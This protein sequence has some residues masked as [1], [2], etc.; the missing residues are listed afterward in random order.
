ML[1]DGLKVWIRC[2]RHG[3]LSVQQV[4]ELHER[5]GSRKLLTLKEVVLHHPGAG[6]AR[7]IGDRHASS[8]AIGHDQ[9]HEREVDH[10]GTL[11]H[12]DQRPERPVVVGQR[13][14]G[15]VEVFCKGSQDQ[16]AHSIHTAKDG[17]EGRRASDLRG[18]DKN[19]TDVY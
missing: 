8:G 7:R 16:H 14:K 1:Q 18:Q 6:H 12:S 3:V 13:L 17:E 19:S 10:Q 9:P 5:L 11:H 2:E 15:L 4:T